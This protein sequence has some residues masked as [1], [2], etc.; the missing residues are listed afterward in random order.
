MA[1]SGSRI[2]PYY[3]P[4]GFLETALEFQPP[5]YTQEKQRD[6]NGFALWADLILR[7]TMLI[8]NSGVICNRAG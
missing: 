4:I 2:H 8:F 3:N 6:K 1:G 7:S 5:N